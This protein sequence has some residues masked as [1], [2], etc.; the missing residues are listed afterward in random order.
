VKLSASSFRRP[1]ARHAAFVLAAGLLATPALAACGG[2]S[3]KSSASG[4]ASSSSASS[5]VKVTGAFGQKPTLSVPGGS[6]PAKLNSEVLSQG[7]GP[8]VASGQTIVVNYLG[9][10]WEPK[11]GKPNVFDNSFDRKQPVN[12]LIGKGQV[13]P[14]WD[15][16]LVGKKAGSRVLLTIPPAEGY[17]SDAS[18]AL[19]KNTLLFV[20]D[21]LGS[22]DAAAT[23]SGSPAG[24]VPAGFPAVTAESGKVPAVTSVKGVAP[25]KDA[26]SAL[27]LKGS[28][29]A[30]DENKFL[31]LNL[32]QVDAKTGKTVR[33]TFGGEG[34]Q[35]VA[36]KD[37]LSVVPS[38][39]GGTVGSRAV[40]V[41]PAPAKGAKDPA[42]VVVLDV[43]G[44]F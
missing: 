18:N 41:S 39:K 44:E 37:V 24:A 43:L 34:P 12:F 14:G 2:S 20:V 38:L 9:Q 42:I 40:V 32:L 35:L 30:I 10:T 23:A 3:P 36:A 4:S 31:A 33:S 27:L 16:T 6:A 26:K 11:D 17:G 1:S 22:Y 19:A 25:G 7:N 28:G 5:G 29:A 13:I 15:K 21:V 8:A